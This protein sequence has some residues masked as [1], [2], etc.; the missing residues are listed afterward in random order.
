MFLVKLGPPTFVIKWIDFRKIPKS[1]SNL[2][3]FVQPAILITN[4]YNA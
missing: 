4:A 3:Y 1:R 2:E